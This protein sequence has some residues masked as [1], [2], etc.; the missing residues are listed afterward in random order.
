MAWWFD[1]IESKHELQNPT[2]AEKIRTVGERM[3]LT[4]DAHI[5]DVGSGRGG[6]AILLASSFGCR[7][8]CVE[9]SE[10]FV[11]AASRDVE[12]AGVKALVELVQTDAK[13]F[14]IE[15]ERYDA[16]LC[17][18]AVFIW[19]SL[20]ETVDTL[21]RGTRVGGFVAVGEPYWRRWP[22]P[23]GFEPE[24]GYDFVPL[25]ETVQRFE[26]GGVELVSLIG[27]STDDWDRYE[28][29][30]WQALEEWLHANP[31]DPDAAEFRNRGRGDRD[32]YLRWHRELLG[33]AI[34]VGRKR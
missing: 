31:E 24:E 6:P 13:E 12:E 9:Q 7:V 4:P 17:L 5:L 29:L 20:Q 27:S 19:D 18:G 2:S 23:A 25:T 34:F 10:E 28:S 21:R 32:L 8:T 22:L 11:G 16:T 30:H 26:A 1:V 33:W 15:S 3:N 14:S